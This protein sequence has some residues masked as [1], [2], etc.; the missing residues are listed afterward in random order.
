MPKCFNLPAALV[1]ATV[2][3]TAFYAQGGV[4]FEVLAARIGPQKAIRAL[5]RLN[6]EDAA[7][8]LRSQGV[9]LDGFVSELQAI[10]AGR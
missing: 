1:A 7:D 2:A 6:E 9:R 10:A 3:L 8:V 5:A 4:M